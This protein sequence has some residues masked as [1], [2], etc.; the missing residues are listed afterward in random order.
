MLWPNNLAVLYPYPGTVV[1][2][3]VAGAGILLV[4]ICLLAIRAARRKPYFI[5]GLFW[6]LGTLVPVIG[7]V[8]VGSQAMADR[9][10]YVPLVGM[11]IIIVWGIVEF[12]VSW[13]YKKIAYGT[14]TIVV[15]SS[16][17][18]TT[19][20]QL[21]YWKNDITLF[22][23]ALA[24]TSNNYLAHNN[25]GVI[26][27]DKG[28]GKEAITHYQKA[29]VINPDYAS[30]H[31]NL[32]LELF[33]QGKF[34]EAISHFVEALRLEPNFMDAH[35]NLGVALIRM[36]KTE[37]AIYHFRQALRIQPENT[38]VQYNLMRALR[39]REKSRGTEKIQ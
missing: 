8:Q 33:S 10:T 37:E 25:L 31:N 7:L 17:M 12:A 36:R 18:V 3:K 35:N 23:R 39:S 34:S 11:F 13:R 28:Q 5:M 22:S 32:G 16:L 6:Y 38:G 19:R 2:W 14:V 1:G 4:L 27:S 21:S 15:L 26:L 20:L 29:L 9:Y 30:A 24:V